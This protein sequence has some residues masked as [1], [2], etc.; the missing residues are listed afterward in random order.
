MQIEFHL[1][2]KNVCDSVLIY[3]LDAKIFQS[4]LNIPAASKELHCG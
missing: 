2:Q 1:T 3:P 4:A